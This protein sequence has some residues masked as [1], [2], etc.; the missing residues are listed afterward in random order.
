MSSNNGTNI[1]SDDE[2]WFETDYFL[3]GGIGLAALLFF[4]LICVCICIHKNKRR[5]LETPAPQNGPSNL[6]NS[7]VPSHSKETSLF[8]KSSPFGQAQVDSPPPVPPIPAWRPAINHGVYAAPVPLNDDQPPT[9]VENGMLYQEPV[10][11]PDGQYVDS[12]PNK[13]DSSYEFD[14]ISDPLG[15]GDTVWKPPDDEPPPVPPPRLS[16]SSLD[17]PQ[18]HLDRNLTG[19]AAAAAALDS[20]TPKSKTMQGRSL[21]PLPIPE[22]KR[23]SKDIDKDIQNKRNT[24]LLQAQQVNDQLM[25]QRRKDLERQAELERRQELDRQER[26]AKVARAAQEHKKQIEEK[27]RLLAQ[28]AIEDNERVRI[29]RKQELDR[30]KKSLLD[31]QIAEQKRISVLEGYP[32]VKAPKPAIKPHHAPARNRHVSKRVTDSRKRALL[33]QAYEQA[34]RAAARSRQV[35]TDSSEDEDETGVY[36]NAAGLA[37]LNDRSKQS[38]KWTN[39]E[40][41]KLVQLIKEISNAD[42]NNKKQKKKKKKKKKNDNNEDSTENIE[43][44]YGD[45]VREASRFESISGLLVTAKKHQIVSFEPVS[46]WPGR[47]DDA[48]ISLL[49]NDE[50]NIDILKRIRR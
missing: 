1:S 24:L 6:S 47:D 32:A 12:P 19:D 41:Q 30:Q 25:E 46:L 37:H 5:G 34:N 45:L 42:G 40:L 21:P 11:G 38:A 4:N 39:T 49:N 31:S 23:R 8:W 50:Q 43:V 27:R 15:R 36:D 17:V 10:V 3:Y 22:V 35:K 48:I 16:A 13:E 26:E 44:T 28:K 18:K 29:Q 9:I 14:E 20:W 33:M 7:S 2:Q